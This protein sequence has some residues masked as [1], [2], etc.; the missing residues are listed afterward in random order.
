MHH[1]LG[2]Q[3]VV[4]RRHRVAA[5]Q[6]AIHPHTKPTGGVVHG[7]PARRGGE[8]VGVFRRD[9]AFDGVA[10]EAHVFLRVAQRLAGGDAQLFLHQVH[11][12]DH[13]GDGVFHLQAGVHLDE[14][15]LAVLPQELQRA[16][17]AVAQFLQRAGHLGAQRVAVGR[18][19][20]RAAGLLHQLLVAALQGTVALAEMHHVAVAIG[21]HLQLYMARPVQ[22]LLQVH[23]VVAEGGLA[24]G[25]GDPPGFLDLGGIARDLHA[26]AA[27]T[28]GGLDQ[29]RVHH[30]LGDGAGLLQRRQLPQAARHQRHAQPAHG[31]LG[32][33][34]VAHH[35]DMRRGRAD[36]GQAMRL[37]HL[38]EAG[39]L[40][41]EA[42]AGVDRLGAGDGGGGEDGSDIQVAVPRRRRADADALVGQAHMHGGGIGGGMHR[43]RADAHLL[44]GA[45]DAERDLAAIGDQHLLE[46]RN[47]TGPP[48]R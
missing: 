40:A 37:H 22:V 28:G 23:G 9:A 7:H 16:G 42:I 46:H 5:V 32:G 33:D 24:L 38:G 11:A 3:A 35:A 17:V 45:M 14:A 47:G 31:V 36:E 39:I 4:V 48:I 43:H 6:R 18:G 19:Q 12:A 10:V 44:A 15:E 1:Q 25:A 29:H 8:A 30:L 13:L 2:H 41:E 27:T 21:H 26:A 34:L 20:H